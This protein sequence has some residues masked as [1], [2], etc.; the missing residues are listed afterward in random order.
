MRTT[1]GV[2][3][4]QFQRVVYKFGNLQCGIQKIGSHLVKL[5]VW[6]KENSWVYNKKYHLHSHNYQNTEILFI[7]LQVRICTSLTDDVFEYFWVAQY[8]F[9]HVYV[10]NIYERINFGLS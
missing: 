6:R 8:T 1:S 5:T 9:V 3:L 7:N 4:Q 10:S 2:P